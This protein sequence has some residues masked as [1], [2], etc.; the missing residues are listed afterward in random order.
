MASRFPQASHLGDNSRARSDIVPSDSSSRSHANRLTPEQDSE[1]SDFDDHDDGH[2]STELQHQR[3]DKEADLEAP[4]QTED[5][6][7]FP[8]PRR[9]SAST[10][11]S[12]QL[13]TPDEERAVVKKFD[14]RL[15][16]FVALLYML[17]F[18]DRSSTSP[19]TRLYG[20]ILTTLKI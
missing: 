10:T 19:V 17:S 14:R 16:L 20:H 5:D 12:F 15:V 4:L 6:V 1:D 7:S 13:Y 9:G 11:H 3:H 18:L 8:L 2:E